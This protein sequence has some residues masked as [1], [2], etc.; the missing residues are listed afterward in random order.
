MAEP[1]IR[2]TRKDVEWRWGKEEMDA[3]EALKN[4][5]IN[6]TFLSIPDPKYPFRMRV[7][8]SDFAAG[9]YLYQQIDEKQKIIAF[10]G[11]TYTPAQRNYAPGHKELYAMYLGLTEFRWCIYGRQIHVQTDHK[12]WQWLKELKKLPK[13]VANWMMELL[14]YDA[15]VEWIPGKT[16]TVAD[17]LSRLW[18]AEEVNVILGQELMNIIDGKKFSQEKKNKI[19]ESIHGDEIHGDHLKIKKTMQKLKARFIWPGMKK[20]VA[21]V[22]NNCEHCLKNKREKKRARM[23]PIIASKPWNII[24]VDIVGPFPKATE[25]DF[26]YI[27]VIVD[28]FSKWVE[29]IPLINIDARTICDSIKKKVFAR[30]QIPSLIISDEGSQLV[31]CALFQQ[32]LKEYKVAGAHSSVDHQ[33]SNGQ[34]ERMI[35]EIKVLLKIKAENDVNN[36]PDQIDFVMSSRNSATNDSSKNRRILFYLVMNRK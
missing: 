36:W 10:G 2:L 16:N 23:S 1:L 25:H 5:L 32:M 4:A 3:M 7:D 11:K 29:L 28:Y 19:V 31:K 17:A 24:G 22:V 27:L 15:T 34:V 21:F 18:K 12:A 30:W 20:D 33:Q 6:A 26:R 13:S 8:S 35:K 14:D 9:Y